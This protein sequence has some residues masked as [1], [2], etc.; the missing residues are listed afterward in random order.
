MQP[1]ANIGRQFQR[2]RVAN[3]LNCPFGL[4]N[5]HRAV[6]TMLKMMLK[7]H[8]QDPVEVAVKVI[9]QLADNTFAVQFASP[10]RKYR[11]NFWRNLSLARSSLDL[12]AGMEI[13][14]V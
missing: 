8:L 1:G 4:V 2:F 7:I 6:F 3:N 12:T 14:S 13:P 11:F 5:N 9:G 10:L